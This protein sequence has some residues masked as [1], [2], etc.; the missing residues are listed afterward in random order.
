MENYFCLNSLGEVL[1]ELTSIWL[2][3]LLVEN[4][5]LQSVVLTY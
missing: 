1:D 3:K 5:I 4:F 2:Y